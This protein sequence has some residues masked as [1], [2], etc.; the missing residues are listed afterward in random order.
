MADISF[1][2]P[3]CNQVLEAPADMAGEVVECPACRQQIAVPASGDAVQPQTVET[4][5]PE[6]EEP[7][8]S[9]KC[10][11]CG[12]VMEEEA[13]LCVNCGFHTKLGKKIDTS[14]G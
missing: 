12:A 4:P 8:A 13:I 5:A 14:L 3:N 2:C 7:P 1:A 6:A 9:R 10:P 11:S